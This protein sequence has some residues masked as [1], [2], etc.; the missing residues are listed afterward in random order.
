[1]S[2]SQYRV[3]SSRTINAGP[4]DVY[5]A[6]A[7][8][9]NQHP[10]IVPPE[11]FGRLEVLEGGTGAGTRTRVVMRVLGTKRVFE[12]LVTEPVPGRVLMETN[13]DGSGVTTFTAESTEGGKSAHVT[14]ATD[15]PARSGIGGLL[16]RLFISVMFPRIYRR[17]L[18][19]LA[20]HVARP[21]A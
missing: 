7:D 20:A 11:Y 9:R 13:T 12:Q 5:A 17:E 1:M 19:R 16:E 21:R 15:L 10:Q 3:M 14:I 6:I 2:T 8:Y 4:A 18:A